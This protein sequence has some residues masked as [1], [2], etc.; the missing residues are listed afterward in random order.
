MQSRWAKRN[1]AQIRVR[2]QP[3]SIA[4]VEKAK[5]AIFSELCAQISDRKDAPARDFV[6]KGSRADRRGGKRADPAPFKCYHRAAHQS[7]QIE[8][9]YR[10]GH[11][12]I[13]I[14]VRFWG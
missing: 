2:S 12:P 13:L 3:L 11:I 1:K 5:S 14:N 10:R 7:N 6:S 9:I 4:D 8:V